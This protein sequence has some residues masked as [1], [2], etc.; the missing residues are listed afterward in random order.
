[1][2]ENT[3]KAWIALY[4]NLGELAR[5]WKASNKAV[6]GFHWKKLPPFSM[7]WP[8]VDFLRIQRLMATTQEH[9]ATQAGTAKRLLAGALSMSGGEDLRVYY[10]AMAH[11]AQSLAEACEGLA[12]IAAQKQDKAAGRKTAI[13]AIYE[14]MTQYRKKVNLMLTKGQ[15]AKVAWDNLNPARKSIHP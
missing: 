13:K 4:D 6:M 8:Q 10:Q 14:I 7:I 2:S 3:P 15:L 5:A 12:K 1:M 9:C 11:Y